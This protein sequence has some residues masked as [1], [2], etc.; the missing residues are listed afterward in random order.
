MHPDARTLESKSIYR[1]RTIELKVDRVIEPDGVET[2][3]EVI[4]H[5]GS[6]VVIP[7]LPD[8]RFVLVRQYRYAAKQS[9]W[10]LVAGGLEEGE[11]PIDGARRELLEEANLHAGRLEPRL[12][13]FP[14]PGILSEKMHLID[15]W[16]LTPG[17]GQPD[18]DER[19]ETGIFSLSDLEGM[20]S[21]R[22]IHDGKTILG[23]LLLLK[24][25]AS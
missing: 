13:F 5:R 2:T 24:D 15:A 3:R 17:K 9:M 23:I 11:N 18:E 21:R 6:T 8:G 10:E 7:H 16:D 1:G 12:D 22:E 14:S 25:S 4:W 19:I 20:I